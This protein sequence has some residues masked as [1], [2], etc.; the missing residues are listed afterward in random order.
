M[1]QRPPSLY[2]NLFA[3][4][5]TTFPVL[6]NMLQSFAV[7]F[8]CW[9]IVLFTYYS[10]KLFEEFSY[11]GLCAIIVGA[12]LYLFIQSYLIVIGIKWITVL[13]SI[14]MKRNEKCVKKLIN[15]HLTYAGRLSEEI[16]VQF[17]ILLYDKSKDKT[18][19]LSL[20]L[21][22]THHINYNHN[23]EIFF[24]SKHK[25]NKAIE[26]NDYELQYP[27]LKE[28]IKANYKR[29][30]SNLEEPLLIA[31]ELK[32][33]LISCGNSLDSNDIHF[34]SLLLGEQRES[35]GKI[36]LNDLYDICGAILYF[37]NQKPDTIV[38]RVFEFYYETYPKI[39]KETKSL[40][41][42]NIDLFFQHY[43]NYFT[44]EIQDYLKEECRYI[45]ETF[46]LDDFIS[47]VVTP[48]RYYPN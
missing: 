25:S 6:L 21:S 27:S 39:Y 22:N 2:E 16:F 11:Y 29:Y 42:K 3:L 7:L 26:I 38:R 36:Y 46:S 18:Q 4:G 31:T 35:E 17:K 19:S 30:K 20:D 1:N 14:E 45:G 23:K 40:K 33:F 43:A 9:V 34:V 13:R 15:H 8:I 37:R 41:W 12:L 5:N 28:I 24:N 48:R 10:M 32:P 47:I 44:E